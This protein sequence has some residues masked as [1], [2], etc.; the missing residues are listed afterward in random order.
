MEFH[1]SGN[2]FA[3]LNQI[4]GFSE[5]VV[6]EIVGKSP[7]DSCMRCEPCLVYTIIIIITTTT[8]NHNNTT[9]NTNTHTNDN[10]NTTNN[11]NASRWRSGREQEG[12]PRPA[13]VE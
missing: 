1:P 2:I 13:R 7:Y 6:G 4:R 12:G 10:N 11:T 5:I 8:T 9:T 3:C